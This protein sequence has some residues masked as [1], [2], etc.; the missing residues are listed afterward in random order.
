MVTGFPLITF[1][2]VP[3]MV[4][5]SPALYDKLLVDAEIPAKD[6]CAIAFSETHDIRN[7]NNV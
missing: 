2:T 4:T 3:V 5:F 6:D 7:T 1:F